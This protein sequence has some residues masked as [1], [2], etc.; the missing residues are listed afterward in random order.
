MQEPIQ[1]TYTPTGGVCLTPATAVIT[2]VA[3]PAALT[4][5]GST[6]CTSVTGTGT[7]TSTTSVSGVSYQLYNSSDAPIQSSKAGN[8]SG[9]T[10]NNVAAGY[11]LLCNSNRCFSH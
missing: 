5:S 4:L 9:L 3:N 6:I 7:I 8:G 1:H 2:V 11:R 10:W